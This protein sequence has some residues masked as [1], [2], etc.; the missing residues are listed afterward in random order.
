M[1]RNRSLYGPVSFGGSDVW[2]C[3]LTFNGTGAW[4]CGGGAYKTKAEARKVAQ[5]RNRRHRECEARDL[6]ARELRR[7]R[8]VAP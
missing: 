5:R 1:S 4:E 8:K 7:Q 3:V 2:W 6:K